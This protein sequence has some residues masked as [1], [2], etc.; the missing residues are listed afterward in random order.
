LSNSSGLRIF[1]KKNLYWISQITG[2]LVYWLL[3]TLVLVTIQT[4]TLSEIFASF[5]L[6]IAGVFI[7]HQYRRYIHST[8]WIKLSIP[9][10]LPRVLISTLVISFFLLLVLFVS[11]MV[12]QGN[13]DRSIPMGIWIMGLFNLCAPVLFWSLIYFSFHF[14]R[15]YKMAEINNLRLETAT[16]DAKLAALRVQ[17][18]PHFLFNSLNNIRGLIDE[19]PEMARQSIT[20]LSN[21]LRYAL[22][23]EKH[24]VVSLETELKTVKEYLF[25]EGIRLEERLK[26]T[27]N[28]SDEAL[29][30]PVPPMMVQTLVENSI[31]HGI[32][33]EKSGGNLILSADITDQQLRI[34]IV[35]TGQ[36][37]PSAKTSEGGYGLENTQRRLKLLY[38][39]RAVFTLS[40]FNA[41]EVLAELTIPAT[42]TNIILHNNENL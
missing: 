25:L 29:H 34:R 23:L 24:P 31:K 3:N 12:I 37:N 28:I 1:T 22:Q 9:K 35:N 7:T 2:W 21:L 17:L 33:P 4:P 32:S 30:C 15:N 20:Q 5:P 38:G 26:V 14:F 8:G 19:N 41:T 18:N 16:K 42:Y 10:L 6:V 40:N 36:L 11:R 39:D 27:I 13:Y